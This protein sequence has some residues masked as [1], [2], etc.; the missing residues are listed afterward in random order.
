MVDVLSDEIEQ[1][2]RTVGPDPDETLSEMDEYAREH[3]FPH[4]GPEVG[5]VLRLLARLTDARRIFEFGSG[6]GYSAYWFA[7]ALPEDGEIVLT[8]VDEDELEMARGYMA[9]GGYDD[10]A[11]YELGDALETIGR[12][13][14]PFDVVLIDHQK[15]RYV[16]AFEAI[17][18]KVPVGGVV[19]AD[20]AIAAG[21]IEFDKLQELIA[22][23]ATAA[24]IDANDHTEGIAD[25]LEHVTTAPAFET[26][27]LPLGEGIA[28]SYRVE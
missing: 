1:F 12:Y 5:G 26:V 23:D 20:N 15:H 16:E 8:E 25:Y 11:W 14:G 4:V 7:E 9:Q 21:V 28:V 27:L 6:Y 13:D 18:E 22:G 3:G 2:V 24:E 19:V 10:L 17:R